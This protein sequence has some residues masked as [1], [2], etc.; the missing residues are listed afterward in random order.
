[1]KRWQRTILW[2]LAAVSVPAGWAFWWEPASLRVSTHAVEVAG[3]RAECDGLRVAVLADLHV[4][5]PH[6]GLGH[7]REIV[8]TTHA[9][10]PDLILLAGD[11]VI[12]GVVGGRFVDPEAAAGV[13]QGLQAPLGVHAVLGNHDWWLDPVRVRQALEARGIAVHEDRAVAIRRG[14]CEFWLAGVS[15]FWEGPHDVARALREIPTAALTVVLTH[16]PD[17]FPEIPPRVALTIAAHTHGGQ[18]YVPGIG[19]PIVPSRYGERYAVGHVRERGHD[20]FV[21]TGIG[22]SI[23]PVRFLVPPEVTLLTVAGPA[24]AGR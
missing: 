20:L 7:L 10:R 17:V 18:V 21:S 14:A 15:D 19:R 9:Q 13:L 11:Y 4:G 1:M 24:R 22:T 23:L 8:A 16:N 6:N 2:A 5:S 12:Q 3:W